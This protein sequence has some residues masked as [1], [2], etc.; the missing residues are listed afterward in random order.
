MAATELPSLATRYK[1]GSRVE[2]S[3]IMCGYST[4]YTLHEIYKYGR[5]HGRDSVHR[6]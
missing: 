3:H 2:F 1:S 6:P 4:S 5:V